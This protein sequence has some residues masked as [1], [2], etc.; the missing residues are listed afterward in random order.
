MSTLY[1]VF[2]I[3]QQQKTCNIIT[4]FYKSEHFVSTFDY[5]IISNIRLNIIIKNILLDICHL[6]RYNFK[7]FEFFKTKFYHIFDQNFGN[8]SKKFTIFR[9][10][11]QL[12]ARLPWEQDAA[13]S[14]PVTPTI[15]SVHNQPEGFGM[16]TRFL[17]AFILLIFL[18][19]EQIFKPA[20]FVYAGMGFDIYFTA[21]PFRVSSS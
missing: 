9:G 3:S 11:A 14:S 7:A 15:S 19:S 4:L 2:S 16:D 1:N 18:C 13:G 12:V 20:L 8:S 17:F 5:F 6:I 21:T 10:V